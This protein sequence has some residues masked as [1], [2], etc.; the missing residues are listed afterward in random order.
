MTPWSRCWWAGP[1]ALAIFVVV[2]LPTLVFGVGIVIADA[3]PKGDV[4]R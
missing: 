1:L 3:W 4:R 2:L